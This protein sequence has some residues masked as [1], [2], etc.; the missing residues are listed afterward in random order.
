M[1][2]E[3]TVSAQGL[4]SVAKTASGA[5]YSKKSDGSSNWTKSGTSAGG[6]GGKS[7]GN[8]HALLKEQNDGK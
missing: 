8:L 2:Y 4:C 7:G 1:K 3:T 5:I 6:K